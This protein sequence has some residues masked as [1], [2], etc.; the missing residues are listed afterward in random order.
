MAMKLE[1]IEMGWFHVI[2]E[3]EEAES[4]QAL[5]NRE[6]VPIEKRSDPPDEIQFASKRKLATRIPLLKARVSRDRDRS[7][8]E[9]R[10]YE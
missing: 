9:R 10:V 3:P 6:N 7:P 8:N 4:D 1:Q 2:S 5:R